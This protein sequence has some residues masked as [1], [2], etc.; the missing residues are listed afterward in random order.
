MSLFYAAFAS[1][2]LMTATPAATIEPLSEN[3]ALLI[4]PSCNSV[5]L[6]SDEGLLL[7][8]D[9]R[10][11]DVRAIRDLLVR[12]YHLPVR[13]VINTH[14]HLD[15][16]GGNSA[17]ARRGAVLIAQADV[18]ERLSRPQFMAAYGN[19]IPASPYYARPRR[20]YEG[21]LTVRFGNERIRLVHTP[22]AHTDGDSL[23]KLERANVLHMG[24]L[25]VNGL[26]P[27]ID[28]SSGGSIQGLIRAVDAALLISDDNTRIVPGHGPVARRADLVAY[29]AMLATV[30]DKVRSHIARGDSLAATLAAGPAAAFALEGEADRFVEAIYAG[31][32]ATLR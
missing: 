20:T 3:A 26:Y 16:S 6:R 25:F 10:S 2:L 22:N 23:V 5:V 27:F 12:R 18:R 21:Q 13:Q 15:H 30:A 29:R 24:D 8:D 28:L 7:V 1:G 14:W 9:Q 19:T 4:G 11:S 17:F 32:T 31:Y